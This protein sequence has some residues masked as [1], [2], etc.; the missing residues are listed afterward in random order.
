[1]LLPEVK[2][3]DKNLIFEIWV[4]YIVWQLSLIDG[5]TTRNFQNLVT[6]YSLIVFLLR[7]SSWTVL[8]VGVYDGEE[9]EVVELI[10]LEKVLD[11]MY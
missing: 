8:G 2:F 5:I 1:M 3:G 10:G 7:V 4:Y 9:R 11:K 6:P